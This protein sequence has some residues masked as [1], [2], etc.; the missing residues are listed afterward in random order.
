M[1]KVNH[2]IFKEKKFLLELCRW[3]L[4]TINTIYKDKLYM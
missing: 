3:G 4:F 2:E 1:L